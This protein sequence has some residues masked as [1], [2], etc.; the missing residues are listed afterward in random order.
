MKSIYFY[1]ILVIICFACSS[2]DLKSKNEVTENK[3]VKLNFKLDDQLVSNQDINILYTI[4]GNTLKIESSES[5]IHLPDFDSAMTSFIVTWQDYSM[6]FS[7]G[8]L[9]YE[10]PNL[11]SP[12]VDEWFIE[13]DTPPFKIGTANE[14]YKYIFMIHVDSLRTTGV[15]LYQE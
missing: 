8:I 11:L 5:K 4:D 6:E 14:K 7:E 3:K 1:I 12:N 10:L 2:K 9:T 15:W 13:I